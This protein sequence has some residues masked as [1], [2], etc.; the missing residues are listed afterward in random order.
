MKVLKDQQCPLCVVSSVGSTGPVPGGQWHCS[1]SLLAIGVAIQ[2]APAR[3]PWSVLL[4]SGCSSSRSRFCLDTAMCF[5]LHVMLAGEVTEDTESRD[6]GRSLSG[7]LSGGHQVILRELPNCGSCIKG[8]SLPSPVGASPSPSWSR[9]PAA[10]CGPCGPVIS[11]PS[12]WSVPSAP[13]AAWLGSCVASS[14]I[15]TTRL[16]V[17]GPPVLVPLTF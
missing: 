10:P 5:Y 8:S 9:R 6:A 13:Q 17:V 15:C 2:A 14:G 16:P 7:G 1:P 11:H 12:A 3:T 4:P